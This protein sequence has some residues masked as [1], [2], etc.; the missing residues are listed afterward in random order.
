[1]SVYLLKPESV[2]YLQTLQTLHLCLCLVCFFAAA[3]D[4]VTK[5]VEEAAE[6]AAKAADN[7]SLAAFQAAETAEG[8]NP[9]TA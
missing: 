4:H 6:E 7:P 2:V 8:A 5:M 1:M 3:R 9:R